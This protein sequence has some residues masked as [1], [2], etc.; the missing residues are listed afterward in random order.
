MPGTT[1]AGRTRPT[2]A[3]HWRASPAAPGRGGGNHHTTST[4][5]A[6]KGEVDREALRAHL[7]ARGVGN[8]VYYPLPIHLQEAYLRWSEGPGSLPESERAAEEVLSLP[9]YPEMT[10]E[11][12]AYV[13]DGVRS[14]FT[15]R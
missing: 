4:V 6:P 11:Q 13:A 3:R 12:R 1:R 8:A 7:Q 14:F 10:A 15:G 5:R 2:I 9:V